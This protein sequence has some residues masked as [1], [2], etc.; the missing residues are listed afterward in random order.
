MEKA[1]NKKGELTNR[2]PW[3]SGSFFLACI[4]IVGAMFLVMSRTVNPIV[5]PLV[6][7]ASILGV[8][9]VGAFQ[10]RNDER[11]SQKSF[12]ALMTLTFKYL[13]FLRRRNSNTPSN[14]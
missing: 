6:L 10:L 12:L 2:S 4:V 14:D 13:P 8:A 9:V 7:I 11:L 3:I 1:K 5:L